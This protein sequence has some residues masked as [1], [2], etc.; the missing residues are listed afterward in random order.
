MDIECP[1]CTM[2]SLEP[3][4]KPTVLAEDGAELDDELN[5][6][7]WRAYQCATCTRVVILDEK[8]IS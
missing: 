3:I 8:S 4:G 6:A 1:Y 2:Q 5:M 7:D